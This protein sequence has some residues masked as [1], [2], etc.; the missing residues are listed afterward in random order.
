MRGFAAVGAE[1][2]APRLMEA[3]LALVLLC[4]ARG[5]LDFIWALRQLN[6]TLAL[7]GAAP[8]DQRENAAFGE[9]AANLINPALASFSQGVRG[10]Y[11]ALAAAAWLFGPFAFLAVTLSAVALLFMRQRHSPSARAVSEIRGLLEDRED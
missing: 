11:F 4:L 5:F 6:Y 1:A 2:V 10:Y 8:E 3:K 7:I 9:A